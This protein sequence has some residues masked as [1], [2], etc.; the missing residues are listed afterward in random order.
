MPKRSRKHHPL[1]EQDKLDHRLLSSF[2]VPVEHALGGRKRLGVMSP[3][4]RNRSG[5]FD[6][7]TAQLTAGRWNYQ[8]AT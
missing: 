5:E 8:I 6:D 3:P 2:R 7:Q 4:L 1:S